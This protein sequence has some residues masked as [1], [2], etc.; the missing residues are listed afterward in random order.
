MNPTPTPPPESSGT[1]TPRTDAEIERLKLELEVDET[2]AAI[3]NESRAWCFARTLEREL[4]RV[5]ETLHPKLLHAQRENTALAARVAELEKDNANL[6]ERLGE[7]CL[8]ISEMRSENR[9]HGHI[10]D[11]SA[12]WL[13]HYW[14]RCHAAL[15]TPPK[16]EGRAS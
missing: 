12:K 13:N 2:T 11:S 5:R 7:A 3:L 1:P 8:V 15:T 4:A 9:L 16:N 10:T 14:P 6:R